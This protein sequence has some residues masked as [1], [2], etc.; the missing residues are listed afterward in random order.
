V[1]SKP[2]AAIVRSLSALI[3]EAR[4]ALFEWTH[5]PAPASAEG[6]AN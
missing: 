6:R 4:S 3:T 1:K 5:F 2:L